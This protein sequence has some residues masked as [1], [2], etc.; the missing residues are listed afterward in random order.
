MNNVQFKR[1]PLS[2]ILDHFGLFL[3]AQQPLYFE[4]SNFLDKLQFSYTSYSKIDFIREVTS[5]GASFGQEL[6]RIKL[7][8]LVKGSHIL[9]CSTKIST[10]THKRSASVVSYI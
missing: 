5:K 8:H 4:D 6:V 10:I 3:V 2:P 9:W 1:G 7:H